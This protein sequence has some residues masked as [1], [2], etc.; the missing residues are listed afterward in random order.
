VLYLESLTRRYVEQF[1]EYPLRWNQLI[2][3][4][5]LQGVPVDPTN[6]P[7]VL[8]P[9]GRIEVADPQKL[10]FI[11]HGLPPGQTGLEYNPKVGV[12]P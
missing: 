11:R 8:R 12:K 1:K 7:Y 5:Y 4:G 9:G 2:A 10:P 3:A 6:T